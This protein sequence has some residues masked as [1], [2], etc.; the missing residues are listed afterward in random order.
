[1]PIKQKLPIRRDIEMK[2]GM[3]WNWTLK[4]R[5]N[6]SVTP[7]DTTGYTAT[8]TIRDAGGEIYKALTIGDGITHTPGIGQLNIRIP[9][10]DINE[11]EFSSAEYDLI[12][13][14]TLDA[15]WCPFHGN[16]KVI[17]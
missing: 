11:F 6:D 2:R 17:R 7:K 13:V 5:E 12:I 14:N 10:T 9:Y 3:D 16:I 1:M 15:H 8:M 4:L